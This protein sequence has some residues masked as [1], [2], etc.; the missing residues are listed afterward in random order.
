MS[1]DDVAGLGY[2]MGEFFALRD[3]GEEHAR[4]EWRVE[5]FGMLI[6]QFAEV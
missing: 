2:D 6:Q 5:S 4:R 3:V 1:E